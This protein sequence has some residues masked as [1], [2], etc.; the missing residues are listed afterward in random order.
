MVFL[1]RHDGDSFGLGC[2]GEAIVDR[3]LS[4]HAAGE[5]ALQPVDGGGQPGQVKDRALQESSVLRRGGVLV[6]RNNIG[7]RLGQKGAHRGDQPRAVVAAK[8]Q[9]ADVGGQR[10]GGGGGRGFVRVLSV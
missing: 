4:G 5:V 3:E 7:A 6:Q 2:L 10:R 1:G 8:Q 9:A